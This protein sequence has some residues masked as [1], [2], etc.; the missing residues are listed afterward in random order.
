VSAHAEFLRA[1]SKDA[2]L[3]A[4]LKRDYRTA[5][6]TEQDRCMLE[7]VE[8]LT[9]Y[10]WLIM[11]E[12]V[13]ALRKAGFPDV[14]ILHIV[15]GSAHFNYLNRMA[16]G[17]GIR[18]EY[19][20]EV[21]E[22]NTFPSNTKSSS[23]A[24]THP[25]RSESSSCWIAFPESSQPLKQSTGP[26]NLYR[27]MSSNP[28]ACRLARDWRDYQMKA[29]VSI[30]ARLR[31][32]LALYISG[33]NYCA[34]SIYWATRSLQT[35][36]EPTF[37]C[38]RL[39]SGQPPSN[40]PPREQVIFLHAERLTREPAGTRGEHIQQLR[41]AGLDDCGILQL[42]MLCSYLSFE[43]RVALGLGIPIESER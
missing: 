7:F 34:Y 1:A 29:T 24:A 8:K 4:R 28:E 31:A 3:A 20:T 42:T 9:L 18:F 37:V 17:I 10:P 14:T 21:P 26:H 35:V 12:D 38:D 25:N 33:L 43:N 30:D 16:D 13:T 19:Q 39:A 36:G 22:R 23:V 15:L 41:D 32:Q 2:D 6:L 40:L 11:N 27:V 5:H